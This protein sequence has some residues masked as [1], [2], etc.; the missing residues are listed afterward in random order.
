LPG[1]WL[2]WPVLA[3]VVAIMS[4]VWQHSA[5]SPGQEY[6]PRVGITCQLLL[7]LVYFALVIWTFRNY[8][9]MGHKARGTRRFAD[10][11]IELETRA[12][13]VREGERERD[14]ARTL[15]RED[16]EEPRDRG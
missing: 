11:Q 7:G 8:G 6:G 5:L 16:E 12:A 15:E 13:W 1:V 9:E 4:F 14:N 2:A 3:F 10:V